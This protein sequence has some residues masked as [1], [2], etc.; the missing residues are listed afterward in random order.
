MQ[1]S[2]SDGYWSFNHDRIISSKDKAYV[3]DLESF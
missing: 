2:K 1:N 3:Y